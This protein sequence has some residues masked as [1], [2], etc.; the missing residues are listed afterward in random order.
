MAV[1]SSESRLALLD[2]AIG[3]ASLLLHLAHLLAQASDG[4][5]AGFAVHRLVLAGRLLERPQA[6]ELLV[7]VPEDGLG[8]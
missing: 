3:F 4:F 1:A 8:V 2:L 7:G 5:G 6:L